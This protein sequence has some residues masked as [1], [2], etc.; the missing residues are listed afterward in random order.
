MAGTRPSSSASCG[1]LGL[2]TT[3]ASRNASSSTSDTKTKGRGRARDRARPQP[4]RPLTLVQPLTLTPTASTIPTIPTIPTTIPTIIP[5]TIPIPTIP[6]IPI[7]TA[8]IPTELPQKLPLSSQAPASTASST[9]VMTPSSANVP[10]LT[11]TK[12]PS[13]HALLAISPQV[14]PSIDSGSMSASSL[15]MARTT[16]ISTCWSPTDSDVDSG[17]TSRRSRVHTRPLMPRKLPPSLDLQHRIQHRTEHR[18]EHQQHRTGHQQHRTQPQTQSQNKNQRRYSNHCHLSHSS[19]SSHRS[20]DTSGLPLTPAHHSSLLANSM[21]P[22]SKR[23]HY[24]HSK[25]Y[26]HNTSLHS[27]QCNQLDSS[28][29]R[30]TLPPSGDTLGERPENEHLCTLTVEL[31]EAPPKTKCF[32]SQTTSRRSL[33]LYG[34]D[35]QGDDEEEE[36]F[37]YQLIA[38]PDVGSRTRQTPMF[39][40]VK[41][42]QTTERKHQQIHKKDTLL[43]PFPRTNTQSQSPCLENREL[44]SAMPTSLTQLRDLGYHQP[45]MLRSSEASPNVSYKPLLHSSSINDAATLSLEIDERSPLLTCYQHYQL[46]KIIT[47]Q[48]LAEIDKIRFRKRVFVAG[49]LFIIS[50]VALLLLSFC[51]QPLVTVHSHQIKQVVAQPDLFQFDLLLS[52]MNLNIVAIGLSNADLDIYATVT[53]TSVTTF[54]YQDLPIVSNLVPSELLDENTTDASVSEGFPELLG[55]TRHLNHTVVFPPMHASEN[56]SATVTLIDPSS[57]VGKLIYLHFP[58]TLTVTGS[59]HYS[60][61]W[62]LVSYEILICSMHVIEDGVVVQSRSCAI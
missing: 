19:S 50:I 15:S 35:D 18:T 33:F 56:L 8:T 30:C 48:Q 24:R 9:T 7:P 42:K 43:S 54:P 3:A 1:R 59:L 31:A 22:T 37:V 49:V 44:P 16:S 29:H 21:H 20:A 61:L 25:P 6:T 58:Y 39:N 5:T 62:T 38:T 53:N 23:H 32:G 17:V 27:D 55:H 26:H 41:A 4:P 11:I 34:S 28:F 45:M 2:A 10:A 51:V 36:Q 60:M 52:G 47:A 14:F 57:S 12:T 13:C 40:R 46:S